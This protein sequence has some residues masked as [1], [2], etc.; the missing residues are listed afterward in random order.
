M[1]LSRR[2]KR[3]KQGKAKKREETPASENLTP[4]DLGNATNPFKRIFPWDFPGQNGD[5][6]KKNTN[7]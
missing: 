1:T 7:K 3:Q 6:V 4:E 5:W 2:L